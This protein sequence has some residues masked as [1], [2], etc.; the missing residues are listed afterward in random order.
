MSGYNRHA[1]SRPTNGDRRGRDTSSIGS[2]IMPDRSDATSQAEDRAIRRAW[3][4]ATLDAY[5]RPDGTLPG[6]LPMAAY[7]AWTELHMLDGGK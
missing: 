4:E 1:A 3:A 6:V 7:A 5:R 2:E